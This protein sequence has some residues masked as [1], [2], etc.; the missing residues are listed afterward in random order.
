M[1]RINFIKSVIFSHKVLISVPSW[2]VPKL[3][4][5]C[6]W[7]KRSHQRRLRKRKGVIPPQLNSV[8]ETSKTPTI[9]TIDLEDGSTTNDLHRG[10]TDSL[11]ANSL[12]HVKSSIG[13]G[14]EQH[15]S[16]DLEVTDGDENLDED[17]EDEDEPEELS[18]GQVLW[19]RGLSRLQTQVSYNH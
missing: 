2:I 16:M 18:Q 3:S 17:D 6:F 13:N 9:D 19:I 15:S 5:I 12:D 10:K 11:G 7:T 14:L 8:D 4:S 1:R